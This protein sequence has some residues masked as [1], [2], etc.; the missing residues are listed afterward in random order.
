MLVW[1]WS[2]KRHLG[3]VT[4]VINWDVETCFYRTM[5]CECKSGPCVVRSIG[6]SEEMSIATKKSTLKL[7]VEGR[8]LWIRCASPEVQCSA[9]KTIYIYSLSSLHFYCTKLSFKILRHHVF[10]TSMPLWRS[11]NSREWV[12]QSTLALYSMLEHCMQIIML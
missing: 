9:N 12:V 1:W 7:L 8:S 2:T 5:L 10:M 3:C 11:R 6:F 4:C